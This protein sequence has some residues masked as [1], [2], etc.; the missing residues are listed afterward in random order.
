MTVDPIQLNPPARSTPGP[1]RSTRGRGARRRVVHRRADRERARRLDDPGRVPRPGHR[2]ADP[3]LP[4]EPDTGQRLPRLRRRGGRLARPRAGLLPAR[5]AGHGRADRLRACPPLAQAGAGAAWLVGGRGPGRPGHSGRRAWRTTRRA[6][7]RTR[8]ASARRP[9]R[10]PP[11]S[12]TRASPATTTR[13]RARAPPR[14]WPSRSRWTTSSTCATTPSASS[15][16][17]A[18]RRAASTPRTRSPS[19]SPAAAS[20]RG[21]PPNGTSACPTRPASTAAT[22]SASVPPAR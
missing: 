20:M 22:A 11:G 8:R 14:R 15:A 3:V 1:Q 19:P 16:T 6:T 21:S 12:A 10:P 7:T 2:H 9:P 4:G 13:P 18:S 17:S 5:G